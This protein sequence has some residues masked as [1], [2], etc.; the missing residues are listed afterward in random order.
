MNQKIKILTVLVVLL[1]LSAC[2]KIVHT[3]KTPVVSAVAEQKVGVRESVAPDSKTAAEVKAQITLNKAQ[4]FDREF[5]Y[6]AD[7]QYSSVYDADYDLY[8][9]SMALGHVP[10]SF[11]K[12]GNEL[13]LVADQRRLYPS[14][15]NHPEQVI[16]RFKILSETAD[17]I[18][19]S[20]GNASLFIVSMM[21]TKK[22]AAKDHWAR[23]LEFV[24]QGNYILQESSVVLPDG[25]ILEVMESIFPKESLAVSA[26]FEQFEMDP[27][28]A[29]GAEEGPVSRYRMLNGESIFRGEDKLALAQHYD[30]NDAVTGADTTID[31][32]VTPNIKDEHLP[33]VKAAVEGWNRYF[34]KFAG[35]KRDVVLFKGRM[36]TGM[37][38]GDPRFNII[39][40]DS[41][42]VAGAAYESQASD[43]FTGKQSHSLIYMPVAWFQ[44]GM[45]YWVN[46]KY[47]EGVA[48]SKLL[49]AKCVRDLSGMGQ[50]IHSG[51]MTKEEAEKFSNQLMKQTLFHEVGHALGLG[52]NFKGSLTYDRQDPKSMFSSS[53]MDYN[54][55]EIERAAFYTVPPLEN[56]DGPDLEYD[57]QAL[58]AIYNK[59]ADVS[60]T[61]LVMPACNDAE[62]DTEESG[63]VDP[64]CV[65]YDLEKDPTLS[66]ETALNRVT[67]EKLAGDVT[68]VEALDNVSKSILTAEALSKVTSSKDAKDL[69]A[70]FNAALKGTMNFY[71]VGGKASVSRAVRVNLRSLHVF[72]EDVLPAGYV[73]MEM[74][75]RAFKGVQ[76][77]A[78]LTMLP[79]AVKNKLN[80]LAAKST[81]L[82]AKT[83]HGAEIDIN[84]VL[85][86]GAAFE[87]DASKGL[88][89][90]RMLVLAAIARTESLPYYFGNS[91]DYETA[92]STILFET[93]S[94]ATRSPKERVVAAK[95]LVSFKGRPGVDALLTKAKA[96]AESEVATATDNESREF[97]I[98]L[99][100]ALEG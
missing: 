54:D 3:Q 51:R 89:K 70:K 14:D 74:R 87:K 23:S 79:D 77:V 44:I 2:T 15:V 48:T 36:P 47:S 45:D 83:G 9:Q 18:T 53:I 39:N 73:E 25:S 16:S 68:L 10:A 72:A 94:M 75:E 80:D 41:R 4:L 67:M 29:V 43:P 38:L 30:L 42:L 1:T 34:R 95:S 66:I 11:R 97:A 56:G 91:K 5:F 100:A 21:D 93:V 19:V 31:W 8:N 62:A 81:L 92:I 24:A 69:L 33:V 98:A 96:V 22:N 26:T 28:H 37:K 84:S 50:A 59:M 64:L 78:D 12:F 6:G 71:F 13:Q 82:L 88:L 85:K 17:T 76:A 55:Y 46:G 60:A 65:R 99:N 57:R 58:S 86:M 90:L 49:K 20:E 7:L 35:I 61:D 52:H 27:E 63:A 40:W 32:Y